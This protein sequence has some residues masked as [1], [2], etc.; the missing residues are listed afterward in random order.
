MVPIKLRYAEP[1]PFSKTTPE[2]APKPSLDGGLLTVDWKLRKR[3]DG[4]R[5]SCVAFR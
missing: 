4:W 5:V 1:L 2:V 3:G